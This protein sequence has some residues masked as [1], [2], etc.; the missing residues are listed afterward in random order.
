MGSLNK[1]VNSKSEIKKYSVKKKPSNEIINSISKLSEKLIKTK[2]QNEFNKYIAEHENIVADH[3]KKSRIK[4]TL[5]KD[6]DGEIKSLGAWG[7]DLILVSSFNK[8]KA[9]DYFIKN[10]Y[11]TTINF[12][13]L[14]IQ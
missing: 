12:N 14:L 1:K 8:K 3:I 13:D 10:K 6:F 2:D 9:L 5:F 4:K 7:G 11:N